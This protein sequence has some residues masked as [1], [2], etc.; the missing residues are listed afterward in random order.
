M[1]HFIVT[2][3]FGVAP[4]SIGEH[5][6]GQHHALVQ[7]GYDL[8]IFLLYGP[9][10]SATGSVAIARAPNHQVLTQFLEEDPLLKE[11]LAAYDLVEFIPEVFP[12]VLNDWLWAGASQWRD[13]LPRENLGGVPV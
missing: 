10:E 12:H 3:S 9:L 5:L 4:V 13:G 2:L 7:D 11:G 8:G 1:R 6:I